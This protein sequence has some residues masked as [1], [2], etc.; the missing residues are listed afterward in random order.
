MASSPTPRDFN[1]WMTDAVDDRLSPSERLEFEALLAESDERRAEWDGF[2]AMREDL[3]SIGTEAAPAELTERVAVAIRQSGDAGA[4]PPPSS[5]SH[6]RQLGWVRAAAVIAVFLGVA[7]MLNEERH[8]GR[9]QGQQGEPS[10]VAEVLPRRVSAPAPEMSQPE[11]APAQDGPAGRPA[12]RTPGVLRSGQSAGPGAPSGE[13]ASGRAPAAPGRAP[14]IQADSRGNDELLRQAVAVV[15]RNRTELDPDTW[16]SRGMVA[17]LRDGA[18]RNHLSPEQ[19]Q[20]MDVG[21]KKALQKRKRE[22][23]ADTVDDAAAAPKSGRGSVGAEL[24]ESARATR[25]GREEES[26]QSGVA[27]PGQRARG[28]P[29]SAPPVVCYV[30]VGQD[31]SRKIQRRL[32]RWKD[33]R[34]VGEVSRQQDRQGAGGRSSD[35]G[36]YRVFR[37][38]PGSSPVTELIAALRG[39]DELSVRVAGAMPRSRAQSRPLDAD[40]RAPAP[41]IFLVLER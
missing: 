3:R 14:S 11:A 39:A 5:W 29:A 25:G 4:E 36:A 40:K 22:G 28:R 20:E 31:A 2:R 34:S 26:A 19:A 41:V 6:L 17:L 9:G 24:K 18:Q 23:R 30:V 10:E 21:A 37:F 32:D 27:K 33:V 15:Y 38:V 12:R 16:A 7:V 1:E 13:A 35:G 8:R